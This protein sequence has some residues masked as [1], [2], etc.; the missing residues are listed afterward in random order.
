MHHRQQHFLHF[1]I[2]F[3]EM[4]RFYQPNHR[5]SLCICYLFNLTTFVND[6]TVQYELIIIDVYSNARGPL[7]VIDAGVHMHVCAHMCY[8][9][10]L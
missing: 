1:A 10:K 6:M 4:G 3:C 5:I 7:Y 2:A 9:S 8:L